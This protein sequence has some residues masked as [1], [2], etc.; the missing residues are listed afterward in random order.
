MSRKIKLSHREIGVKAFLEILA[1][2]SVLALAIIGV[3]YLGPMVTGLVTVTKQLNYSDDVGLVLNESGEY[4]WVLAN[5]GNLKSIKIDGSVIG[6]GNA[7]VYAEYNNERR[8]IFDSSRLVEKP[9]GIFGATGFAVKEDKKGDNGNDKDNGNS[10]DN[11]TGRGNGEGNDSESNGKEKEKTKNN[12]PAWNSDV[13]SFSLNGSLSINLSIYFYDADNDAMAYSSSNAS[14]VSAALD[15]GVITLI[16]DNGIDDTRQITFAAYDGTDITFKTAALI[17]NTIKEIPTLNDTGVN[18]TPLI[19]ETLTNETLPINDTLINETTI[20][21]TLEKAININFKYGNEA[22]YDA[23]NDGVESRAGVVDFTAKDTTFSWDANKEKL[24][25]RYEIYSSENM[26]SAFAC[27]GNSDCCGLVNMQSS[28]DLW[29]ESLYMSYGDYGSTA[30]NIVFAQVLY[31]DYNLDADEPYSDVAYSPWRNLTAAFEEGLAE[32]E[33]VCIDT[34]LFDGNASSYKL[35]IE[36]ENSELRISKIKYIIEEEAADREPVLAKEIGN[37]SV[38]KDGEYALD[39]SQNFFDPDNDKLEYGYYAIGNVTIRFEGNLA[40]IAPDRGFTGSRF[41]YI[42][43]NDSYF[44]AAS[45]IFKIDV[46]E[47][48]KAG[49]EILDAAKIGENLT[50]SFKASGIGN[51]TISMADGTYAELYNDN[52]LTMDNLD[53]LKLKCGDFEVFDKQNLIETSGLWLVL[54]NNSRV[55]LSD[56]VQE[57][58]PIRGIYAEDYT[59]NETSYFITRILKEGANA[60]EFNFSNE[61][62]IAAIGLNEI[63]RQFF[64]IRDNEG[65]KLAVFDSF[66]NLGI[67][68]N[69]TQNSPFDADAN[70]FIIQNSNGS[71]VLAITNPEG[72]MVLNGALNENQSALTPGPNSYIIKNKND[73]TVAYVNENGSMF[74]KGALREG[75]LNG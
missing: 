52:A 43:A 53:I 29:N 55:K 63:G 72:S 27:F 15:D 62:K 32:F 59:C 16:P 46:N 47:A 18:E 48:G 6:S 68:G 5:P 8:L 73:E 54:A 75:G 28:G 60:Q 66:G 23:N 9:S 35:V 1:I 26:E 58:M 4:E 36:L 17:I 7:K 25:T 65:A 14:N 57:S 39:L 31:A 22:A 64:E 2:Y 74:L 12:A 51:L 42:T 41:T 10:K 19:N 33:D 40:Y 38:L 44:K 71:A 49:I 61:V 50:V 13:D 24:C 20:N 11:G 69:L 30:N 70:D 37:I 45:N 3:Y 21:E 34:C 56:A 67:K